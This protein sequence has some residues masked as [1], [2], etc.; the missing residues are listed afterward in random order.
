MSVKK[1]PITLKYEG[2]PLKQRMA[3][4]ILSLEMLFGR[5]PRRGFSQ[6]SRLLGNLTRKSITFQGA[7]RSAGPG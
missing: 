1:I 4:I 6:K 2:H 5:S 3:F 7:G